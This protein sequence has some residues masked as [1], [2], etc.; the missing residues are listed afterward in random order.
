MTAGSKPCWP[1]AG[2]PRQC[3]VPRLSLLETWGGARQRC[4]FTV[5]GSVLAR[6]RARKPL[7]KPVLSPTCDTS[8]PSHD[9]CLCSSMSFSLPATAARLSCQRHEHHKPQELLHARLLSSSGPRLKYTH[10][11]DNSSVLTN[12]ITINRTFLSHFCRFFPLFFLRS[13]FSDPLFLFNLWH[14]YQGPS[15]SLSLSL[16]LFSD[17]WASISQT[18]EDSRGGRS[19]PS[20]EKGKKE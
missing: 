2:A 1:L 10:L 11:P 3:Q 18:V 17:M 5:K 9:A 16:V 20:A 13:E 7:G 19:S 8:P 12:T 15:L 4:M 14:T 6:M